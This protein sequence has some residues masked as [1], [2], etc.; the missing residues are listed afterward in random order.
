MQRQGVKIID[1]KQSA[2][3]EGYHFELGY[4]VDFKPMV[5]DSFALFR[6]ASH[7]SISIVGADALLDRVVVILI[8]RAPDRGLGLA[9]RRTIIVIISVSHARSTAKSFPRSFRLSRMNNDVPL[10]SH[11]WLAHFKMRIDVPIAG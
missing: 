2:V 4:H 5:C 1:S 11:D 8:E 9:S 10:Q 7:A 6:R 3:I